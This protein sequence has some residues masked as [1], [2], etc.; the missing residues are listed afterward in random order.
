MAS[1]GLLSAGV[2]G[3]LAWILEF[4]LDTGLSPLH[5][6][7]V[8]LA[9]S[10][11]PYT[12]LFRTAEIVAGVAFVLAVPP[13]LRLVP[14]HRPA[15]STIVAVG[16]L[17]LLCI[18]KGTFPLD[19]AM[20][21]S[22]ACR[23]RAEFSASHGINLAVSVLFGLLYV[24]GPVTVLLWWHGGWRV[25]PVLSLV[26]NVPALGGLVLAG[27][28]GP[29]HFAG[30]AARAQLVAGTALLACGVGYLVSITQGIR[31]RPRDAV[32]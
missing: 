26:V 12:S 27:W 23:Q 10:D 24:V 16:L 19:C 30:L 6:A 29:G 22:E 8:D 3:Q 9:A 18:A 7:T 20:S 5:A 32:S 28:L 11:Q 25:V 15:R 2:L 14:V 13:L 21:A 31:P 17:G 1:V 4:F